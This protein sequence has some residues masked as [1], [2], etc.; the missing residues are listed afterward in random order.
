MLLI[1]YIG[2]L[3]GAGG[4]L[5]LQRAPAILHAPLSAACALLSGIGVLAGLSILWSADTPVQQLTGCLAVAL[6][7]AQG[8]GAYVLTFRSLAPFR[9]AVPATLQSSPVKP[10]RSK[11]ARSKPR[12]PK[13]G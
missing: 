5:A 8:A 10:R 13:P 11:R 12:R 3:A 9:E 4:W 2:L 6:W 1:L 7:S